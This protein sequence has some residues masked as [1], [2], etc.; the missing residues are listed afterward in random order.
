MSIPNET[1]ICG[2]DVYVLPHGNLLRKFAYLAEYPVLCRFEGFIATEVFVPSISVLQYF[3]QQFNFFRSIM[4]RDMPLV[5]LAGSDRSALISPN[6]GYINLIFQAC[7]VIQQLYGLS[8][9]VVT[10]R[11][12]PNR[13]VCLHNGSCLRRQ[14]KLSSYLPCC[15][16]PR[17][18]GNHQR[19]RHCQ[20]PRW[21]RFRQ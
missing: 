1:E 12:R 14:N 3:E 4:W 2:D 20:S 6:L 9:D 18:C 19:P 21:A 7:V 17:Q 13:P 5:R 16:M 8:L 15:S 10:R 11:P